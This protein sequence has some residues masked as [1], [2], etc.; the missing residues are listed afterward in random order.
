MSEFPKYN[1]DGPS[2]YTN[3]IALIICSMRSMCEY[4][5]IKF[6]SESLGKHSDHYLQ[7]KICLDGVSLEMSMVP[8]SEGSLAES[9]MVR[10][11]REGDVL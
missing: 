7:V 9:R 2:D 6:T 5:P 3:T 8:H 10:L 11:V 1:V 4:G